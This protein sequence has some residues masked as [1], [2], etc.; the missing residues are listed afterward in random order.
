MCRNLTTSLPLRRICLADA[1]KLAIRRLLSKSVNMAEAT[2]RPGPPLARGHPS[3][4][5]LSKLYLNVYAQYDAARSLGKSVGSSGGTGSSDGI[6]SRGLGGKA[7]NLL[8]MRKDRQISSNSSTDE[9]SEGISQDLRTYLSDGR[10]FSSALSYKWLGVDA[11]ENGNKIGEAI[12]WLEMARSG[13]TGLQ[14]KGRISLPGRNKGKVERAKRKDRLVEELEDIDAFLK[15]YKRTNGTVLFQPIP[16]EATLLSQT[17]AGRSALAQRPYTLPAPAFA[18]RRTAD[19]EA[20]D[21]A[22]AAQ[23]AAFNLREGE[24]SDSDESEVDQPHVQSNYF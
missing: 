15:G 10:A 9:A 21:A 4:S 11:G 20:S 6:A 8:N 2:I 12:A 17:P 3:P 23:A 14:G 1:E 18:S 7:S 19:L 22:L 24:D 16:A 13:V 5:L